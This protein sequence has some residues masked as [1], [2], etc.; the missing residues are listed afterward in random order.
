MPQPNVHTVTV[1]S[2]TICHDRPVRT[3]GRCGRCYNYWRRTGRERPDWIKPRVMVC[4]V[5]NERPAVGV[6]RCMRCTAYLRK[7]GVE[8]PPTLSH[9]N[10]SHPQGQPHTCSNGCPVAPVARGFCWP[11]YQYFRRHGHNR[12]AY[13]VRQFWGDAVIQRKSR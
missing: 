10:K 12:P 4:L 3:V 2:C 1:P 11:C 6:G 8:R 5:C 7:R 13:M 9:P